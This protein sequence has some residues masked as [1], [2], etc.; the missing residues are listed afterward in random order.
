MPMMYALVLGA[1]CLFM[2]LLTYA[3]YAVDKT[4]ARQGRRRVPER[5]LHLL[6]LLGGWPGALLAQQRLRHKTS[7]PGFQLI[8]WLSVV[9]HGTVLFLVLRRLL[10]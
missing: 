4:A 8:F 5:T 7:K 2:S 10:A 9:S 3:V 6:A 1:V